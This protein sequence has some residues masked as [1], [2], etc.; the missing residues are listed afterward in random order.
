MALRDKWTDEERNW[1]YFRDGFKH[2]YSARHI[3]GQ[4]GCD[5]QER[6][7]WSRM[8]A[9]RLGR[10]QDSMKKYGVPVLLLNFGDNIRYA[11]GTWDYNWKGNNGTRYLLV[12]QDKDPFFFDTVGMDMEVTRMYCSW[13]PEDRLF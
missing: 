3:Y 8:R 13:I 1:D 9:Y 7:N 5:F 10:L 12:F 4:D 2:E 6:I 11:N